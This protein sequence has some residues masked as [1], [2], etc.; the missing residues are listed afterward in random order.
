MIRIVLPRIAPGRMRPFGRLFR[1]SALDRMQAQ[2]Q[3]LV[4]GQ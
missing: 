4:N 2:A 1:R 3:A